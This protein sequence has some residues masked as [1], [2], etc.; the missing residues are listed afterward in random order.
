MKK[1]F[2]FMI[3]ICMV[4]TALV[5]CATD[6]E[7]T[8]ESPSEAG[9][10]AETA[11]AAPSESEADFSETGTLNLDWGSSVG[12][13]SVF[14]CPWADSQS[15]VHDMIHATLVKLDTDG[16]TIVPMLAKLDVSADG[17]TYTFTLVD[18]ALW[19]DG[20]PFS[21]EDVLFSY[22]TVVKVPESA[23]TPKLGLIEGVQDV[24]DGNAETISGIT[25]DGNK[26]IFNLTAP[27]NS[28][29]STAFAKIVILPEHLLKDVDPTLLLSYED[30]WKKPIGLGPYKIDEMSYPNYF[31]V[32]RNDEYFGTMP[33][34]K[35]AVFTSH[36]TGGV[37]SINADMIAGNLDYVFGKLANDINSAKNIVSQNPDVKMVIV[38][39]TYQ[40]QLK[41][42]MVGSTDDK[43]NDDM[44]KV[45]VRQGIKSFN[46]QRGHRIIL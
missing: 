7:Q 26:V 43:Y 37:E 31:T 9:E 20:E 18:N 42:N 22:N 35:K 17:K 13:D 44:Q 24:I 19:H 8:L 2:T 3:I 4:I 38:P 45:E 30:Y 32:V 33:K 34:I 12:T 16:K 1:H 11:S 29:I 25:A 27:D 6:A 46:R 41:I 14:E 28:I 36:I 23:Y 39:G 21:A 40:R 15:L 10:T 5:G